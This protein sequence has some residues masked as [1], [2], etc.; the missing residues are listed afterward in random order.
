MSST[1]LHQDLI[2]GRESLVRTINDGVLTPI[3]GEKPAGENLVKIDCGSI[4]RMPAPSRSTLQ[5]NTTTENAKRIRTEWAGYRNL[6]EDAL[7]K[8]SKDIEL[9]IFLIEASSRVH[10]FPGVRDGLWMLGGLITGFLKNGLHPLAVDGDLEIQYGKLDWL[11]DRFPDVICEIPLTWRPEPDVNYSL[12]YFKESRRQ[13]GMITA[14]EF[15]AAAA[16]ATKEQYI[17]LINSIDDA[18][19]EFVRFKQI[20]NESYGSEVSSFIN[21]EET[22]EECLAAAKTILR[23]RGPGSGAVDRA[24]P[25]DNSH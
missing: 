14:A 9:G 15:D 5:S 1:D 20:A 17:D 8:C 4:L 2:E 12:N 24:K 13:N 23:K 25:R 6:V 7:C 18:K 3:P 19:A 10:G 11:N 16:A 22:L 21:A